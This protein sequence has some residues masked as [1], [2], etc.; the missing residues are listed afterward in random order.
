MGRKKSVNRVLYRLFPFLLWLPAVGRKTFRPDFGAGIVG[1][2]LI[3]PQAIAL[4]TLAGMPPEYG[5]YTSIIPVIIA[6][7]WSSSWHTLSGPNTAVCVLIAFTVAPFASIGNE[8]YIGYVLA[9]TLMVGVIQ[10]SLGL[11]KLGGLLDFISHTVISA[12]VLAVALIIIISAMSSFLGLLSNPYEPFFIRLYQVINDIP[13]ANGFAVLIGSVTIISGLIA[14][15]F[16]RRYSLLVAGVTGSLT[17]VFISG[18]YGPANT[19]LEYVGHMSFSVFLFSMPSIDMESMYVLKE[20]VASAFAIAL[21]GLMQTVIIGRSIATK[22]GQ[23][24]DANQEAISQGLSNIVAPF[25]SSFAGSGSFNRSAVNYDAGAKTPMAA[26]YASL[27][28][29]IAVFSGSKLI[30]YIPMATVAG[31]LILVGYGLINTKDTRRLVRTRSEAIIFLSTFLASLIFGLTS[32]VFVGLILSL[33][34]FIRHSAT[35]NIIIEEHSAR[36]GR[37]VTVVSIIG[38][39][40]F[41]SVRH[42][43]KVLANL[44]D[45]NDHNIL[46]LRTDHL[47]YID[48]TGASMIGAEVIRRRKK[49]DE[50]YVYVTQGNTL[51]TLKQ[52]GCLDTLGKDNIIH[53]DREH[54]MK[55][56]VYPN[57]ASVLHKQDATRRNTITDKEAEIGVLAKR[58]RSTRLLGPLTVNQ[59][60]TLL[61]SGGINYAQPGEIIVREDETMHDHIILVSGE[62]EAQ[63]TWKT[64]SGNEQ[65]HTWKLRPA[66]MKGGFSFLGA[67]N[68]VRARALTDVAYI[69]INANSIDELLSWN[70]YLADDLADN[71]E[72]SHRMNLVK[73][74]SA[75]H[76]IPLEN[77]KKAFERMYTR[78]VES[79][80][81]IIT[82]GELGDCYYILDSGEADVVRIDPFTD[83]EEDIV[84]LSPGDAFGEEALL[85]NAYRNAT[86]TMV[87]PGK[88]LVLDKADFDELLKPTMAAEVSAEEAQ[89]LV[90]EGKAKW[91]DCRYDIEFQESRIPG[92][93][94][95]SL[96]RLRW[97]VHNIDPEE[98]YIVY[99]RSGSRSMAASFLLRERN[100]NAMSLQGGIKD[101]PYEIDVEPVA[102]KSQD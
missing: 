71:P 25:L 55:N 7:L 102:I 68:K 52:S 8:Y 39:L 3:L 24:V 65:S 37:P 54:P 82:R 59:I 85:Q 29:A 4:A 83:E 80:E 30:A 90:R 58:L 23:Q 97:D 35:P 5:I 49:G 20:L 9:L 99:C 73:Q 1:A 22:S 51:N 11:L 40:F 96:G 60:T 44:G 45:P 101:W 93:Q 74:V 43:E 46:L 41:G 91:L 95:V 12:V 66:D 79:G 78:E 13:R 84:K 48:I 26:I 16:W 34:I 77:I 94:F 64:D 32:G 2:I 33:I 27:V 38:N 56:I 31:L 98:N 47:T 63:R 88:L 81:T 69:P 17:A 21:L 75:F 89:L 70:Q 92:A 72:L 76:K 53:K 28:L 6:S 61:E 50:V 10:F 86:V 100:I 36:D 57:S 62:L 19:H 42:I 14:R 67:I 15:H 87:T 18:I